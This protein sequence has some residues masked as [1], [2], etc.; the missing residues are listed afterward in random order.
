MFSRLFE[1]LR[2]L[3]FGNRRTIPSLD[4][5][6]AAAIF[7]VLV[8]HL[9]GT[10]HFPFRMEDPSRL[11][12]FGVR[13][14]F[15]ISGYLITS[16][17][18]NE[19]HKTGAISLS[20][21]YFRRVLRLFPAAYFLIAVVAAMASMRLVILGQHDLTFAITY[22]MNYH[23]PAAWPLGHLW[24]LAIE[25][26][27]YFLWPI[28]LIVLAP[29]RSV[30]FL[31]VILLIAPF[32]RLLSPYVGATFN[33]LIW[34]DVLATGCLLCL[35][36]EV[37]FDNPTYNRILTSRW[38]LFVPLSAIVADYVPFTKISWLICGTVM[39]VGIAMTI[40]WA[41]RNSEGKIGRILN[42]PSV[43]FVGVLSY[44]LYL[45]QQPFLNRYSNSPLCAF[46]L[47]MLLAITA[48]LGSYL[49]IEVPVLRLRS[50]A[51]KPRIVAPNPE[52]VGALNHGK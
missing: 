13:I 41:I 27:F 20:Q 11:G 35:M 31:I 25:E 46:P 43:C 7:V 9:A 48:A 42:S 18:L 33:F 1:S 16:L 5:L 4:G 28:L 45:W 34:S 36:R 26:Q 32:L 30:K 6:R 40:D 8:S 51:S 14:F 15:V 24:S 19:L 23:D 10:R 21:F 44:S 47:N 38:F 29:R 22:S 50:V 39:N 12:E 37:L 2:S 49:L 52:P 17:L 3:G